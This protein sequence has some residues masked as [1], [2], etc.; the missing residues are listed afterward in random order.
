MPPRHGKSLMASHYFPAWYL[1]KNPDKRVIFASYEAG[2]AS[3]WGRRARNVLEEHG[4]SLFNVAVSKRSSAADRWDIEGK[5]GGMQT[6][7]VGGALTGKGADILIVDDPIKNAEEAAS[8]TIREKLWEW[9]QSTA[10]TRLEPGASAMVIQT[11]WHQDDL[12]GRLLSEMDSGGEKWEVLS[13][14]AIAEDDDAIGRK[15]GQAL[16]PDRFNEIELARMKRSVGSRVWTSLYQQKPTPDDGDVFLRK[17]FRYYKIDGDLVILEGSKPTP[18]KKL[19]KFATVDLAVSEKT[20]ADYT[21]IQI[22]GVTPRNEMVL[23]DQVREHLSGPEI[24]PMMKRLQKQW[25]VDW[26]GVESVSFQL[27]IVQQARL[28]GLTVKALRPKGDKLAR[29]NAA[30]PRLEAGMVFFPEDGHFVHLL[31]TELLSFPNGKH[32]DMVDALSY[33]AIEVHRIAGGLAA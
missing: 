6:C 19:W 22:W 16:W 7:G 30:S 17:W 13:M 11:R 28:A 3:Q 8:E 21:V 4:D 10:Y 9:W 14:P 26:F 1:G 12:A 24:V 20:D 25:R 33:A 5:D 31:E 23:L 15:P 2:F 27:S 32:D 18:I 29:A